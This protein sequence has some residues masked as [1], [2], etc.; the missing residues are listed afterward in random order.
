LCYLRQQAKKSALVMHGNSTAAMR[1][2]DT[3]RMCS[4]AK[5]IVG[6]PHPS[7]LP[8]ECLKDNP[9][10]DFVVI[11]EGENTLRELVNHLSENKRGN[12]I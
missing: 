2:V 6:G 11:G 5:I 1:T 9:N 7:S 3:V 10:I 4:E 12:G 8:E